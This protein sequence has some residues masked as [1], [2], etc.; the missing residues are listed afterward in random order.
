[1]GVKS[2]PTHHEQQASI[3]RSTSLS[4]KITS[5]D[6]KWFQDVLDSIAESDAMECYLASEASAVVEHTK[7]CVLCAPNT[8]VICLSLCPGFFTQRLPG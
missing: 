2:A 7:Q 4:V 1:M 5:R 8:V 6:T 3:I